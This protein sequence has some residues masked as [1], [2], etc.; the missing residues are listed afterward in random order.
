MLANGVEVPDVCSSS[1]FGPGAPLDEATA[2]AY[3]VHHYEGDEDA[4]CAL[5]H[6]DS[7]DRLPD[8]PDG[9]CIGNGRN[10]GEPPAAVP[11]GGVAVVGPD[12]DGG[13][14]GAPGGVA[15]SNTRRYC[16]EMPGQSAKVVSLVPTDPDAPGGGWL[17]YADG[18]DTGC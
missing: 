14:N 1:V 8:Q 18:M 12:A 16:V 17:V 9:E 13:A 10:P 5:R 7:L 2:C 11:V 6:P 15:A 4:V 3:V